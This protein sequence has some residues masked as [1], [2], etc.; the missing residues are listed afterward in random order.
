MRQVLYAG[1]IGW[2]VLGRG[3]SSHSSACVRG[4]SSSCLMFII[5]FAHLDFWPRG[6]RSAKYLT[7]CLPLVYQ[8][9]FKGTELPRRPDKDYSEL[10]LFAEDRGH[11][12]LRRV[13]AHSGE[14]YSLANVCKVSLR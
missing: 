14:M 12:G 1:D 8:L 5:P 3:D 2:L 13:I 4:R 7:E 10:F 11:I 9:R 6:T